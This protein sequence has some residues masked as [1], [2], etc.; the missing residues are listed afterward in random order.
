MKLTIKRRLAIAWEVLTIHSGR[1]HSA[2]EK[3]TSIF[4]R[5]YT[6]GLLDGKLNTEAGRTEVRGS[7]DSLV[8]TDGGQS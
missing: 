8:E 4:Q 2:L 6:A 7:A 1:K 5:G 3:Q